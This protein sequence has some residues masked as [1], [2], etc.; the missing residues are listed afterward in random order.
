MKTMIVGI[1]FGTSTTVVRYKTVDVNNV[2]ANDNIRALRVGNGT[3][4]IPTVMF[5]YQ[6]E[7]PTLY[8]SEA[9]AVIE[10]GDYGSNKPIRNFKMDLLNPE[11]REE[12]EQCIEEFFTYLHKQFI[13]QIL[14]ENYDQMEVYV[15]YPAK[16]S[17]QSAEFMKNAVKKAG[18]EGR[19]IGMKEPEA[20]AY[21]ML[22]RH[23]ES[24][25]MAGMLR[26][27]VSMHV[28]MLDMGAGTSDI[29]IFRLTINE[30]GIP[31][32]DKCLSYPS[33][34][35][36]CLCGGR[37]IDEM[38]LKYLFDYCK[39]HHVDIVEE[40]F[41][42]SDVK[43]WKDA[44][45]S[46]TLKN[47]EKGKIPQVLGTYLKAIKKRDVI[48]TF[49]LDR[50]AFEYETKQHWKSLYSLIESAMNKYRQDYNS[51]YPATT[52]KTIGAED[53]DVLCLTGGHSQWYTVKKLFNGEGVNGSIG[54]WYD[55][56]ENT[57]LNFKKLRKE[58]WRI[59]ALI[60]PRPHE[61]VANGLCL[62]DNRINYT[63]VSA[64]NVW[65]QMVINN[66]ESEQLLIVKMGE[67]VPVSKD[68][69]IDL[70]KM[71][72]D[73]NSELKNDFRGYF[74]VYSGDK[75]DTAFCYEYEITLDV[76][77]WTFL[78]WGHTYFVSS[79][80]KVAIEED[81]T[82]QITGT[83]TFLKDNIFASPKIVEFN[84]KTN[85]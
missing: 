60:D 4:I 81:N 54:R 15:S 67:V 65:V 19:I 34:D 22:Y 17:S 53:I 66:V 63:P 45:L 31:E 27:N 11:K 50:R 69:N 9:L 32:I 43:K 16:W 35:S 38:L 12:A 80:F 13:D 24:F 20:A 42:I 1:D 41:R 39:S 55:D 23:L 3:D 2:Y 82:L 84:N 21:N 28:F 56:R 61:S 79:K 73:Y 5:K 36:P 25:K 44:T 30:E 33:V 70:G 78:L 77:F 26:R 57:A 49:E 68:E 62:K 18:F 8:G 46:N 51:L 37:E 29:S 6:D 40:D 52:G 48:D 74:K 72:S 10:D 7:N 47:N 64:N 85:E 71:A 58:S 76:D 14:G 59:D 75:L 83:V